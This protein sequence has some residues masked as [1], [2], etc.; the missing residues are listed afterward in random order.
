[1]KKITRREF[2]GN[3]P[4]AIA[5]AST[6]IAGFEPS[7]KIKAEGKISVSSNDRIHI[8]LIGCGG[9]GK[10]DLKSFLRMNEIE[11]LAIADVDEKHLAE[12]IKIVEETRSRKPDG[13]RDFRRIM[14]RRDIDAVIVATPDHWHALPVIYA[15][16][17]G[18]DVYVEKPLATSIK[19]GRVM[20]N[21]AHRNNRIVQVGTQQRSAKHFQD[22][23]RYVKSGH[24]GKIRLVRSWTYLDWKGGL[25]NPLDCEPPPEVDYDFWLGPA[26][27]RP[28]NPAR[29][30]FTFRWFWDYSGG[31]MTDWG[32]HMVDVVMWAMSEDPIGAMAIGGKYGFPDD[33]METPDTQQSIVE[34]P[35]FSLLWEHMI[36]C[37]VGPWQREHGVEFHGSNGI[38]VVDRKGWEVHSET[39]KL[40]RPDRIYR[41][42]A[43]PRQEGSWDYHF[44]HVKNFIECMKTRE[45]PVSEIS[46]GHKAATVC[47]LANIAVRLRRYISWDPEKEKVVGDTEA[48]KLVGRKYRSPWVLPEI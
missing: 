18:K 11:C 48:Q 20:V 42:K 25:G 27:K 2:L 10:A 31:L 8:A 37:G 39:D 28:F 14:D 46:F 15:C 17:T 44:Y 4:V 12:G 32:A 38:L 41:M 40:G 6:I 34:F 26:P 23:V 13:Y 29:F 16:Q 47:H 45:K 33:I 9:M 7:E 35:G 1:M 21:A 36:G 30:H 3:S 43:V 5:G 24:L 19:E 22:A